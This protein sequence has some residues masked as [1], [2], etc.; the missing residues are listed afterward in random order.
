MNDKNKGGRPP[1]GLIYRQVGM[2]AEQWN[3][4]RIVAD[5]RG[6]SVSAV[7]RDYA[8]SLDDA[9]EAQQ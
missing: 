2:T 4:L 8:D 6:V 1:M 9:T 5:E 3:N 7:L